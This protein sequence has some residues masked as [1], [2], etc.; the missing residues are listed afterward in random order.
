MG[1]CIQAQNCG[2]EV[3]RRR[4]LATVQHFCFVVYLVIQTA[5]HTGRIP[6]SRYWLVS[7]ISYGHTT[8]NIFVHTNAVFGSTQLIILVNSWVQH[9]GNKTTL[10]LLIV[11]QLCRHL[12]LFY[13]PRDVCDAHCKIEYKLCNSAWQT[14]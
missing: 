10:R 1:Q 11:Y 5:H 8:Y 12:V 14:Y 9:P 4:R 3:S 13:I 2:R 7:N 6:N